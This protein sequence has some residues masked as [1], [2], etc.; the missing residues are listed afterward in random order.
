MA[1]NLRLL[2]IPLVLVLLTMKGFSQEIREVRANS[3]IYQRY[4]GETLQ[5]KLEARELLKKEETFF[6]IKGLYL[7]NLSKG[8]RIFADEGIYS[9]Q[10]DR[11][12]LRGKVKLYAEREGEVYTE[13]LFFYPKKDLIEIPGKVQVRKGDLEIKGEGLTYNIN[14]G[15]LKIHRRAKAQI[16]FQ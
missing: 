14:Q 11:F 15:E 9:G 13:E 5:W 6:H 2:P 7:E 3:I 8:L 10:E 12:I 1:F 16:R 4:Q